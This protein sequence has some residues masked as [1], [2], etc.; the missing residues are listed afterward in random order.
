MVLDCGN[1]WYY[2]KAIANIFSLPNL[3]K[4]YKVTFDSHQYYVFTVHSNREIIKFRRNK[5]VIYVFNYTY[6]QAKSNG[7]TT[8]EENMMGFTSRK[9]ERAKLSRKIYSNI[10]LPTVK[11]FNHMVST[12]MISNFPISVADI[13]NAEKIYGPSMVSLKG[14]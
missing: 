8:M 14:K 4:K 3:V 11:N 10:G 13:I 5:Q 2:D 9:I 7:V 1:V 6:I 12:S